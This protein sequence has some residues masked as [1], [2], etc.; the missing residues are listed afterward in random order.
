MTVSSGKVLDMQRKEKLRAELEQISTANVSVE[1]GIEGDLRGVMKDAQISLVS[2]EAW[3][4]A[5]KDLKPTRDVT[6][7][8]R[9]ANIFVDGMEFNESTGAIV[10]IGDVVLEVMSETD[11]CDIMDAAYEGL[12][13]AL[14]PD[15][16]GGARTRVLKPGVIRI[17][18]TVTMERPA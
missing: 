5:M 2:K 6:W 16:R 12:K 3:S 1:K 8:E 17:G 11:P 4:D 7:N 10:T 14:M 9:R 18:D 15:W 13:D